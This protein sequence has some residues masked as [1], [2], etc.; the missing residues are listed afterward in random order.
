MKQRASRQ[1][2]LLQWTFHHAG[3][4]ITCQ[5]THDGPTFQLSLFTHS[6][7]SESYVASY[8][9]G[10]EAM[11]RHAEIAKALRNSGWTMA[12]YTTDAG[13]AAHPVAA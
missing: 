11:Q 6:S 9:S 1:H 5:L 2:L 3:R 7:T 12:S 4:F 8:T 13:V 10:I